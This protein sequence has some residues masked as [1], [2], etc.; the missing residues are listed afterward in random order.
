VVNYE[1]ILRKIQA[2]PRYL[3]GVEYGK[4]RKGHQEGTIKA[5]IADLEANLDR[6][7]DVVTPEEYWKLKIL[8]HT[9]DTMKKFAVSNSPIDDINS[10]ASLAT[11]FLREFVE[12]T[13]LLAMV[14]WHDENFAL[15]KQMKFKGKYNQDRLFKRVMFIKDIELFLIFTLLDGFTPSKMALADKEKPEKIRWFVQEVS[16]YRELPRMEMVLGLFNL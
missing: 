12:D 10:H 15:W 4:P 7:S 13:D 6:L 2:D 9:H 5:H 1:L 8:I 3:E 16:Q 14:Q 11:E